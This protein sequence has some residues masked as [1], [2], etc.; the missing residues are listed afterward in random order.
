MQFSRDKE[1][2][3]DC[4]CFHERETVTNRPI[5]GHFTEKERVCVEIALLNVT[6]ARILLRPDLKEAVNF[7]SWQKAIEKKL[8]FFQISP[9]NFK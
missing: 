1:E 3:G 2:K 8:D 5:N 6:A 9:K 7:Y 4:C